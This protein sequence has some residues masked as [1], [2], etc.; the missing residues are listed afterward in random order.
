MTMTSVLIRNATILPFTL[1]PDGSLNLSPQ[2]ADVWVENDRIVQVAPGIKAN[3][4]QV[5]DA[6]HQ[7]LVPGFVDA[8]THT[9]VGVLEKCGY[10]ALPLE[11]IIYV[12]RSLELKPSK[13]AR[14]HYKMTC[15]RCLTPLPKYLQQPHRRISIWVFE[16]ACLST[17]STDRFTKRFPIW[18][19]CYLMT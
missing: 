5:F 19:V 15:T 11:Y 18:R 14:R 16:P 8:H 1:Q 17:P 4:E 12:Q 10:E 7:L 9:V 13:M 6:T 3:A 2:T